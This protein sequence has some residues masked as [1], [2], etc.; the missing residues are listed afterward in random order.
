MGCSQIFLLL[1][2]N[3]LIRS[4][5]RMILA[6]IILWPII[7]FMLL[8]TLRDKVAP[9]YHPTC[10]FRA[11]LMPHDGLL[12]FVQ[13]YLCNV[14]NPC[15]SLD[16]YEEFPL[17]SKTRLSQPI[18]E[19]QRI[20]ENKTITEA[21]NVLPQSVYFL[22][23]MT[24]ILTQPNIKTIFID[25]IKLGDILNDHEEVKALLKNQLS[26]GDENLMNTLLRTPINLLYIMN[27]LSSSS[28]VDK[29]ICSPEMLGQYLTVS[30]EQDLSVISQT[31]C[32]LN[33]D[34]VPSM[35]EQLAKYFNFDRFLQII[36]NVMTKFQNYSLSEDVSKTIKNILELDM[37]KQF[38]PGYLKMQR[39]LP[40]IM[41]LLIHKKNLDISFINKSVEKM[42]PL[43]VDDPNW[44]IARHGLY[45]LSSLIEL[46]KNK[47]EEDK[48]ICPKDTNCTSSKEQTNSTEMFDLI[49]EIYQDIIDLASRLPYDQFN[50]NGSDSKTSVSTS[51]ATDPLSYITAIF[52]KFARLIGYAVTMQQEVSERFVNILEKHNNTITKIIKSQK[53]NFYKLVIDSFSDLSFIENLIET[54]D[55]DEPANALCDH[56]VFQR[57]FTKSN[58]SEN[59]LNNIHQF[60]CQDEIKNLINDIYN[61]FEFE[62][63]RKVVESILSTF[64]NIV[65]SK[66]EPSVDDGEASP[67]LDIGKLSNPPGQNF[68]NFTKLNLP[69]EW[70]RVIKDTVL[71]GK[72]IILGYY[73]SIVKS[74][75]VHSISYLVMRPHLENIDK[76]A[77]LIL[78]D[79]Q[80]DSEILIKQLK[81]HKVQLIETFYLTISDIDRIL[82][83]LEYNNL[84][85]SYCQVE[86]P[87][88]LIQYPSG[89][90][91][92]LL[93]DIICRFM[94][95]IDTKLNVNLK[96]VKSGTVHVK[97]PFDW[98][99]L[100]KKFVQ[101]YEYF[102]ILSDDSDVDVARLEEL[103][104]IFKSS[105]SENLTLSTAW[106]ISIGLLCKVFNLAESPLFNVQSKPEW[107]YVQALAE[108]FSTI[109]NTAEKILNT[110]LDRN[111]IILS[112]TEASDVT[113]TQ[114]L[115]DSK[116]HNTTVGIQNIFT[117]D[118]V[119]TDDLKIEKNGTCFYKPSLQKIIQP[120]ST[121]N[122]ESYRKI[123]KKLPFFMEV[124]KIF[125]DGTA[126]QI[127]NF[128]WTSGYSHFRRLVKKIILV[129]NSSTELFAVE[130]KIDYNLNNVILNIKTILDKKMFESKEAK[131]LLKNIQQN[132]N[133]T[134]IASNYDDFKNNLNESRT[135]V[136]IWEPLKNILSEEIVNKIQSNFPNIMLYFNLALE[137]RTNVDRKDCKELFDFMTVFNPV[138]IQ[139]ETKYYKKMIYDSSAVRLHVGSSD[140]YSTNENYGNLL[141]LYFVWIK[142]ILDELSTILEEGSKLI[143][144]AS[145]ADFQDVSSF[146]A[147]SDLVDELLNIIKNKS[148][149]KFFTGF[150]KIF[151]H[152]EF[153]FDSH[154]I[155]Q[156][157][158]QIVDTLQS[159]EIFEN[160]RLLD[161]KITISE[162]FNDWQTLEKILIDD[163]NIPSQTVAILG[164]TKV[165]IFIAILKQGA[166]VG[167]KNSVCAENNSE[168]ILNFNALETDAHELISIFCSL[169]S[170]AIQNIMMIFIQHLKFD[171]IF[172]N[173]MNVNVGT[174]LKNANLTK[175][176]SELIFDKIGVNAKLL[177]LFK[178][179]MSSGINLNI[180]SE[181]TN[182][183]KISIENFLESANEMMCGKQS[184]SDSGQITRIISSIK[185]TEITFDPI[186]LESLPTDFCRD[187]Y[188][189]VV[190][191]NA[192]KI[193]WSYVKPLIRGKILY[194]PDSILNGEIMKLA[195]KTFNEIETF[196]NLL[197][198]FEKTLV[199]I[200]RLAD[201]KDNLKELQ[202]ILNTEIMKKIIKS[203]TKGDA[204]DNPFTFDF[205]DVSLDFKQIEQ[206]A[207]I[208][209]TMNNFMECILSNRMIG[210]KSEEELEIEA[211][212]LI[213]SH[214][215]L[216]GVIFSENNSS[217][218]LS[219]RSLLDNINYKIRMDVDYV[220]STKR[221]KNQFWIPGPEDSFIENLKYLHG[222]VQLQDSIDR[223]I[224][225]IKTGK[226]VN[227]KT[228]TQQMPY[229]CWK[230]S[231]FQSTLYESQGLVVCF[232]FTLM[233]CIGSAVHFSVWERESQNEIIMNVMGLNYRNNI[234]AWFITTFVELL[235][236]CGT[237]L[238]ILVFG[239]ILPHSDPTLLFA[240][241]I[242]YTFSLIT[243][244]YMIS[245]MF[246]SASLAAVTTIVMFLLTY[247]PYVIVIAM[248]SNLGLGY[249]LMLCLSMSTS[250]SYG[251][252][253]AARREVQGEGL[254]WNYIW[255]D[256]N[257]G[258]QMSLGIIMIIIFLDAILYAIIGYFITKH[259]NS[260]KKQQNN[261]IIVTKQEMGVRFESVRKV[262]Q[263]EDGERVAI[264]DFTVNLR[265]GEITSLLGRNGAGK[266]TI[267]KILTGII[268]PTCGRIYLNG[269]E[270]KK[271]NIGVCPQDNVLIDVLTPR[272]H[273]VFY[274]KLK[275]IMSNREIERHVD[276]LLTTL[277]LGKK[278][279][280]PVSRLSG[281]TKR[282][283]CVSLAFLCSPQLVILD[284]PCAG[285][286][287]TS[288]R[289]IWNLI[290]R[291]KAHTTILLS[292][293]HLDEAE[294]LSDTIIIL[295]QGKILYTG[296]PLYLKTMYG[297]GYWINITF[298]SNEPREI[299]MRCTKKI[300]FLLENIV[301]NATFDS[302]LDSIVI[303][304]PFR[305]I[306]GGLNDIVGVLKILEKNK[307]HLGFSHLILKCDTLDSI[308]LHLCKKDE[309]IT[310]ASEENTNTSSY[311]K[312]KNID[313]Y[314]SRKK[315]LSNELFMNPSPIKQVKALLKKR[316]WHFVN[317]WRAPT[318]TLILPT[319]L[320]A[321]AMGFSLIRPPSGDEPSLKL[322]PQLYNN[323]P[324]YFYSVDNG[325]DLFCD[326]ISS[327]LIERFGDKYRDPL[328]VFDNNTQTCKCIEGQ[329]ICSKTK[330][331][332]GLLQ[333]SPGR[334]T[335]DW[336]IST[337][338][339]YIEN[340][341][342][343]WT[344]S[345]KEDNP[346][347]V[348][349]FNNKGHHSLPAYL[350][351]LNNAISRAL[352][353]STNLNAS[354]HPL[355][356]SSEQ[357]NRTTILQH[358]ADVGIAL[359]LLIA[360]NLVAA[361]GAKEL[362]RERLSE[363]KCILYLAGVHPITYW[364]MALIW[365]MIM[366][367]LSI[368]LA[369]GVFKIFG[370]PAYTERDNLPGLCL[371][372]VLF[373]WASIPFTHLFEKMFNNSSLPNMVLFCFNTFIGVVC[374]ASI[375][376]LD[377]VGTSETT[378]NIRKLLHNVWLILP[379]YAL[380]DALIEIS[381]N[382]IKAD[383]LQ[384]FNMNT[385][386]SPLG[387]ELVGQHYT[388]LFIVGFVFHFI[389]A[390]IEYNKLIYCRKQKN[391]Y[392]NDSNDI[393][394]DVL[395]ERI[396]VEN[397]SNTDVLKT[398]NLTKEFKTMNGT[399]T[400]VRNLNI[401]IP[402]GTCF[403][404][405]GINGA[406][407]S[408]IFKL[409]TTELLPTF[410][411][412]M[413]NNQE[414][415]MR[416]PPKSQMSY[417]PQADA[418]DSFL[419]PHQC[420]TI[421]GEVCGFNRV[422]EVVEM[423]LHTFDLQQYAHQRVSSLSGGNKRKLCVAISVMAPASVILMDEPTSGMDPASKELIA[424]IIRQLI[425]TKK[426]VV[427]S[428]HSVLELEKLCDRVGILANS[429]LRCIG[430]VQ[431]LKHK[432]GESYIVF[433]RFNR[434]VSLEELNDAILRNLNNARILSRQSITAQLILNKHTEKL[435]TTFLKVKKLAMELDAVDYTLTQ[436][437]LDQMLSNFKDATDDN[438]LFLNSSKNSTIN[439]SYLTNS[440]H[441]NTLH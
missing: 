17:F 167:M 67:D 158:D 26:N 260:D 205:S 86:N 277:E 219:K 162:M 70:T 88:E 14:G 72:K 395:K 38:I 258:N 418:L 151:N 321:I 111:N 269:N 302:T 394:H 168:T 412:I 329:Q 40:E 80:K 195:N 375:L 346:L 37:M 259:R 137:D 441:M 307:G 226:S 127:Y 401:S 97:K 234:I 116:S 161:L 6:F 407:K 36:Q 379:Q 193:I 434:S 154:Q 388:C 79:L 159:M 95:I 350:N 376:V 426:V 356:L 53:P 398:V 164:H 330:R 235:I 21:I 180:P 25:G 65:L 410:G 155:K 249:N 423:M 119:A 415:G 419:S 92:T 139:D 433:L 208:I 231:S 153:L 248:E 397:P 76:V 296:S 33:Q 400:A 125:Q 247:M 406:G 192:G 122:L 274:A 85:N 187:L 229:P 293:H 39:W 339:E 2:K 93:K 8:Y 146:L 429:S 305:E 440:M 216:A 367:A 255:D 427:L 23:S 9:E 7:I 189:S 207:E 18:K 201:V 279:N 135:F 211:R 203:M 42:D 149:D 22:K 233:I 173:L 253:Y 3:C 110:I 197:I 342:G 272:E 266:T 179:K 378:K 224:I 268:T 188:K 147:N 121:V 252:L 291:Y 64:I 384:K 206:F 56:K 414:I 84:Y 422:S 295:N 373:S 51:K 271:P 199:A 49:K 334:P 123:W 60:L 263:I 194:A 297:R 71:E 251:C 282:R 391:Y 361:Q 10:Q 172:Q 306:H 387:W 150:K 145:K 15:E 353:I 348:I 78:E 374:L 191:M 338:Q 318:A 283:L 280:E 411:K 405:L 82:D 432:F 214:E 4:R 136:L 12:P 218:L 275:N 368:A 369:V 352:G 138:K 261:N 62:N 178:D 327:H 328:K 370:I 112:H 438:F 132:L 13:S 403:G 265:K 152:T 377:I 436:T 144:I 163:L 103:Q 140:Y 389:N 355:K 290:E 331:D 129:S 118:E 416:P 31:L 176:D 48:F 431:H 130:K 61:L 362:V 20:L 364:T 245:T 99:E 404:L 344:L 228:V 120:S 59:E 45:K 256:S 83:I 326:S 409:L 108:L 435:S 220:P 165:N 210:F 215:F 223:A 35:I 182:N 298:P 424:Y 166:A 185:E 312:S 96:Q 382:H 311:S 143:N 250:F 30:K 11:R 181:N 392:Q 254:Q 128:N 325:T 393:D 300:Q 230:Y 46:L 27:M 160:L 315:I 212:Q 257:F 74:I 390:L 301:S 333:V 16:Q 148:V 319:I 47:M 184:R 294:M 366:F 221:L 430:T 29:I 107:Q 309:M 115:F 28:G 141:S 126:E 417:C 227:W 347:F 198:S 437:S 171:Y 299:D 63:F 81:T 1:W 236:V 142:N 270:D 238:I 420:L 349:W 19:F 131:K 43:F 264:D 262:Y 41:S 90:N 381:T 285:V 243:F 320:V 341:Y 170:S 241:L 303:N 313:L 102:Y 244:C 399:I 273:M 385:Y 156:G 100:N 94:E 133:I 358:V 439:N 52:S 177:M 87:P 114:I 343:G 242:D 174:I 371:L 54:F 34:K 98:T 91:V 289:Q 204:S 232:F 276:A 117:V 77:G 316:I 365:D 75:G 73:L 69:E 157:L 240:L 383:L 372:L 68:L 278:Q 308:F 386:K 413:F 340:R 109:F 354:N 323:Q 200:S 267:I 169:N 408:T 186:E 101:L 360:F 357:L 104:A 396:R 58:Y 217:G 363:E 44:Y 428:S 190:K 380:G 292:T 288:R 287:P 332:L 89:S 237:I 105:W 345:H 425:K 209:K 50:Q 213:N 225:E 113:Q 66:P 32:N 402:A 106:E 124:Y 175:Q 337:S 281:G 57:I 421:H 317:D 222:F 351:A 5:H 324:V 196:E 55:K 134:Y 335:L 239:K 183:S 336:I 304:L 24:E 246:S 202:E 284:E 310:P 314:F 322:E 286:D 359:V